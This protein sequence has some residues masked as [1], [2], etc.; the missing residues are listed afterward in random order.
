MT[1][2][3]CINVMKSIRIIAL[4][5]FSVFAFSVTDAQYCDGKRFTEFPIFTDFEVDSAMNVIYG[6]AVNWV[7]V[8][9]DLKAN[10][11]YPK[12]GIDTLEK[13]PFILELHSG[14]FLTGSMDELNFESKEFAKRGYV[15]ATIDYRVGWNYLPDC[16][17]DTVSSAMAI[18]RAMQDCHAALRYFVAN[19][20]LYRIDTAYIFI[21]GNSAGA[22]TTVDLA[23][24]NQD[25]IDGR[26]PWCQPS[27]G[28]L[29]ASGNN[30]T[31]TF[32][33]KGLFHNWGSI[34]DIDFLQPEDAIPMIAFAGALDTISHIDSGYYENCTN[35]PFMWGTRAIYNRLVS[36][37]ECADLTVKEDGYHGVYNLTEAQNLFRVGRACCFFKSLFCN[38]CVTFY[39]TDSIPATCSNNY[40]RTSVSEPGRASPVEI[41][42]DPAS[43]LI[44]ITSKDHEFYDSWVSIVD[45]LGR[46]VWISRLTGSSVT[47]DVSD[48]AEGVYF[49]GFNRGHRAKLLI[50]HK[51]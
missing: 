9:E 17:G 1:Y 21:G 26:Y 24:V 49:V 32:T 6:N 23:F 34:I 38:D 36:F 18:Y 41:F 31:D 44:T 22:Y 7:G 35:Y 30:L 27:L 11:Y 29:N 51:S 50:N 13:R 28:N 19:A 5:T 43:S 4:V 16:G 45:S 47:L 40:I 48:F 39:S 15:A 20:S 10:I 25:E 14:S 2:P 3:G 46:V 37:G 33:L 42:P 8:P 12:I